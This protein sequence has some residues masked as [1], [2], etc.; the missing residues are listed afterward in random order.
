MRYG[1]PEAQWEAITDLNDKI[2]DLRDELDKYIL[3]RFHKDS[4]AYVLETSGGGYVRLTPELSK[5]LFTVCNIVDFGDKLR[6]VIYPD[7]DKACTMCYD[8]D[9]I[10][11]PVFEE[12]YSKYL[13]T[14]AQESED[15]YSRWLAIKDTDAAEYSLYL[16]LK[17]KYGHIS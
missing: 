2:A 8:C 3:D 4:Y 10:H 7:W 1:T 12:E 5:E 11:V 15:I 14:N 6:G 16:K 13:E 9:Y 17:D